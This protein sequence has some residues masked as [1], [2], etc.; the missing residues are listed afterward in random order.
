MRALCLVLLSFFLLSANETV[1]TP[2]P[3]LIPYTIEA[4]YP[5]DRTAFTQGLIWRDGVLFET[6]GQFGKSDIRRVRLV[7]GKPLKTVKLPP[8]VFGEGMTDWHN[9]LISIT[10]QSG[11]GYRWS[12]ESLK[13]TKRFSYSGEGWGLTQDGKRLYMS[14]GTASIR[15]L[16]PQ[17]FK[18]QR[19][20]SVTFRGLPLDQLNELEWAKGALYANVWQTS[21]IVR[22]DPDNGRV[23]GVL[24]FSAL[25]KEVAIRDRDA[26][27]NGIA[28]DAKQD[29]LLVTGKNW[30]TLF[31]VRL[32]N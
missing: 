22:I 17:S 23:I 4:R 6:T 29:M 15:V 20:I 19:R 21:V 28:Y 18:E 9:E 2:A 8:E 14:D 31:A 1:P 10:W 3:P 13:R 16:D 5:H 11:I 32:G 24:D 25:T 27:L 30:P 7:D 12:L 26:V